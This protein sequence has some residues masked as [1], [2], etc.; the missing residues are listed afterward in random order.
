MI[1]VHIHGYHKYIYLSLL[2]LTV[3]SAIFGGYHLEQQ[4]KK[5]SREVHIVITTKQITNNVQQILVMSRRHG[6]GGVHVVSLKIAATCK[7]GSERHAPVALP[8]AQNPGNQ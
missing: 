7:D 4:Q 3:F 6:G 5:S 8:P 1:K 2:D